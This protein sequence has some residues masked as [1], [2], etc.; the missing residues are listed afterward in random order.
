MVDYYRTLDVPKSATV[1]QIKK[2]YRKLALKWHPDKNPNNKDE[3]TRRFKDISEA[4]EVLSDDKK[5]KTYDRYGKDGV[6]SGGPSPSAPH[7]HHFSGQHAGGFDDDFFFSHHAFRDPNDVFREFFGGDPLA[8]LLDDLLTSGL[9]EPR[10]GR[11]AARRQHSAAP[12][13]MSPALFSPFGG[14]GGSLGM[15]A[16]MMGM[17][18]DMEPGAGFVGAESFSA[19]LGP[20]GHAVKRTSTSTKYVNG[21]KI[22]T[23]KVFENGREK[24]V[25]TYENDV[26]KHRVLNGVPQ[27]LSAHA[28]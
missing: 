16:S 2:A 8:D 22:T 15:M 7:H 25:D 17:M 6:R 27:R 26:L 5:R 18:D 20:G 12:D 28:R 3:A 13:L 14:L 9:M 1:E 10:A 24:Q 11:R 23:R 4:Y 19:H 21:K